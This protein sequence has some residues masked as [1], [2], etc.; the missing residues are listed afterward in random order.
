M[1]FNGVAAPDMGVSI[2]KPWRETGILPPF[3]R[4]FTLVAPKLGQ[5]EA[6][7]T[8]VIN[9]EQV[10][11][12]LAGKSPSDILAWGFEHFGDEMTCANSYSIEDI[13]LMHMIHQ[14]RAT[15][16]IFSLDTGRL[17]EETYQVAEACRNQIQ[18]PVEVY[19]PDTAATQ[20]M[21]RAKGMYSFYESVDNRKECCNIR[22]VEPLR[23]ALAGKKAW[24][25]GLRREQSP[26][27]QDLG[28]LEI[29]HGNGGIYKLSPLLDWN[30]DD[31]WAY[32]KSH[33][34]PYNKL[35]DMGFP[36][37][38]CSP[39][40]RAIKEGEDIRAGR[41]WWENP[42]TKECGLHQHK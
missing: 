7:S 3:G 22:K 4:G 40:T 39:C 6:M 21:V 36:S 14:L 10:N 9:V 8:A 19:F 1:S 2:E 26:T 27:R 12:D 18:H 24:V 35:H 41:W 5:E 32:I 23:R 37:I 38:G 11:K 34:L 33:N 31:V 15:A 20:N 13:A 16:P 30:V 17:H 29:D 25:V 28:Y 42:D